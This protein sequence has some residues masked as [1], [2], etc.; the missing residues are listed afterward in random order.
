MRQTIGGPDWIDTARFDVLVQTGTGSPPLEPD[1]FPAQL[2]AMIRALLEERFSLVVHNEVREQPMY[3]LVLARRDGALGPGLRKLAID[4]HASMKAMTEGQR[5]PMRDGRGPDCTFGGPPGRLQGNAITIDM[6][7][8]VLGRH[9]N[10]AV[11]NQTGLDGNFD[12]DLNFSPEFIP[13]P[14]GTAPGDVPAPASDAPS[15]FTA[16]HEQLGLRLESTKGPVDVLIVDRA[17]RPTEH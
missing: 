8:R 9:V 13:P 3:R 14:P 11:V 6:L 1:G 12:V 15:I 10:R 7:S 17:E 2:F 4:C 16:V 5:M